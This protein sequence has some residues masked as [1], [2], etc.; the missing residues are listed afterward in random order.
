MGYTRSRIYREAPIERFDGCALIRLPGGGRIALG[1]HPVEIGDHVRSS[2]A[3]SLPW[4]EMRRVAWRRPTPEGRCFAR[5]SKIAFAL[6]RYGTSAQ[7]VEPDKSPHRGSVV[8]SHSMPGEGVDAGRGLEAVFGERVS[9]KSKQAT[10][11]QYILVPTRDTY[12]GELP[13]FITDLICVEA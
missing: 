3:A 9:D 1:R 7:G 10:P 8:R 5:K 12:A 2:V 4:L 13:S 6:A 11:S